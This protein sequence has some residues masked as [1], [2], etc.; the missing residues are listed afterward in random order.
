MTTELRPAEVFPPGEYLRDELDARGWT[1]SEFADLLGRPP[2]AIS[3]ILNG[4]KLITLET[5]HEIGAALGTS[6]DVWLTLQASFQLRQTEGAS[7]VRDVARRARMRELVPLTE[8][9]NRGWIP[10]DDLG[11]QERAVCELVGIADPG[12]SPARALAARRSNADEG[13]LTPAQQAWAGRVRQIGEC[14]DV[15][16]PSNLRGLRLC[17]E[18]LARRLVDPSAFRELPETL[19]SLGVALVVLRPLRGSKIDGAAMRLP[20]GAFV[21]GL[22]LRG[23]RFDTAVFTLAHELAHIVLGHVDGA[24]GLV[25]ENMQSG[26]DDDIEAEADRQAAAWLLPTEPV[27]ADPVSQQ[28]VVREAQRIRCHPSL[29]VGRLHWQGS[30]PWTHLNGLIPHMREV[31]GTDDYEAFGSGGGPTAVAGRATPGG[32]RGPG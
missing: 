23:L 25:D 27:L 15:R 26:S 29:V 12:E 11:A 4:H 18:G 6:A 1:I 2:Q 8:I 14:V 20:S 19:A 28:A 24:G 17:A 30:L 5:A 13:S 10:S 32:A 31:L 21:V 7:G 9:M 16:E 22:S 3:E